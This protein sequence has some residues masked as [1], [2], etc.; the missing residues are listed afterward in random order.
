M[1][2]HVIS[3]R[4]ARQNNLKNLDLE[5]PLGE[6]IVVTTPPGEELEVEVPMGVGPGDTFEVAVG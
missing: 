5:L 6:L 4:Q 2:D 3:I 1:P